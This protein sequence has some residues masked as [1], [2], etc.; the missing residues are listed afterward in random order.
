MTLSN[1]THNNFPF[2]RYT[3]KREIMLKRIMNF[4]HEISDLHFDKMAFGEKGASVEIYWRDKR[5]LSHSLSLEEGKVGVWV[6]FMNTFICLPAGDFA[7]LFH[8]AAGYGGDV[9]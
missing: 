5:D 1:L 6:D 9:S 2:L 7:R 4:S 3:S 8:T